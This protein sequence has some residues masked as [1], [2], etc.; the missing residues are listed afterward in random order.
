M[1][2]NEIF[3]AIDGVVG[4]FCAEGDVY[5]RRSYDEYVPAEDGGEPCVISFYIEEEIDMLLSGLRVPHSC[6]CVMAYDGINL[7]AYVC[8]VSF[9]DAA[10]GKLYTSNFAVENRFG[11]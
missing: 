9:V 6:E 3:D 8:C 4:R 7:T 5:V 10:T 11:G 1:T 2:V